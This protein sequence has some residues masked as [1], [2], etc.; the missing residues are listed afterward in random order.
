MEFQ[1]L[2]TKQLTQ[3]TNTVDIQSTFSRLLFRQRFFLII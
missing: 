3:D 2:D 1:H